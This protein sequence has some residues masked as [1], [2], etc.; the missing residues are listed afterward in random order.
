M[1]SRRQQL[2]PIDGTFAEGDE[3][4]LRRVADH[5]AQRGPLADVLEVQK[6]EAVRI[7]TQQ[8]DRILAGLGNPEHVHLQFDARGIGLGQKAVEQRAA[9][10]VAGGIRSRAGDR[11]RA[12]RLPS[13]PGRPC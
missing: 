4:L 9:G 5:L 8:L 1:L 10:F 2:R 3:I 7:K 12:A 6:L 13:A 11:R